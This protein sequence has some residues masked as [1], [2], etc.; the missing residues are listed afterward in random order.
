MP[1]PITLSRMPRNPP[2]LMLSCSRE[3]E[4]S[5]SSAISLNDFTTFTR[6]TSARFVRPS[7]A[8]PTLSMSGSSVPLNT[9]IFLL[10]FAA[11]PNSTPSR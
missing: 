9:S 3:S 10:S 11:P 4:L 5:V 1:S 2:D 6:A 7:I 8:L